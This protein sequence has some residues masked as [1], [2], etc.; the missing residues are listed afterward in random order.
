MN[1]IIAIANQKGGVGKTTT[2]INL[3]DALGILDKKVLLIDLD[4]QANATS[5][6]GLVPSDIKYS[7]LSFFTNTF[8][9]ENNIVRPD[10]AHFDFIPSNIRLA[11]IEINRSK[12]VDLFMLKTALSKVI[13]DYHYIIIDCSPS[14]GLLTLNALTACHSVIIPVQCEFYALEGLSKLLITI[15]S[16]KK[17]SNPDIDIEGLLITMYDSRTSISNQLRKELI[18]HF[19]SMVFNT[20]IQRN[21]KLREAPSYGLSIIKYNPESVGTENYLNLGSEL[22]SRSQKTETDSEPEKDLSKILTH[23]TEDVDFIIKGHTNANSEKKDED[24]GHLLGLKRDEINNV[25]GFSYNDV[26]SNVWMYRT[27]S[28]FSIIKKNYLYLYFENEKVANY[29]LTTFKMNTT[30]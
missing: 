23:D 29:K 11:S 30:Q 24:Y 14:F 28:S 1:K 16:I 20:V 9:V 19:E 27:S 4:P 10:S 12:N 26:H 15:K 7:S 6:V 25:L 17:S 8:K 18:K 5:G 21:V 2:S 3:A 13:K 22:I